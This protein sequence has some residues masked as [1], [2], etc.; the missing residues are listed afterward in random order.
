[1]AASLR[2]SLTSKGTR[3]LRW[4]SLSPSMIYPLLDWFIPPSLRD[5]SAVLQRARMFLISHLFGP[6]LGNTITIYLYVLEPTPDYSVYVLAASITAFWLFPF[7]LKF[8]GK[9]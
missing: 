8:T 5:E 1:M 4:T 9:F 6:L 7:A 3:L 2:R